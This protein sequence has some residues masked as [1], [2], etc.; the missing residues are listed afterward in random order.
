MVQDRDSDNG[1]LIETL[2][3]LLNGD[4]MTLSDPDSVFTFLVFVH[5][6]GNVEAIFNFFTR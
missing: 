6:F 2:C 5:I 1:R 4:T 3:V